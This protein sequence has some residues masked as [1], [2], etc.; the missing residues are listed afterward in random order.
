MDQGTKT[1]QL[2]QVRGCCPPA[3]PGGRWRSRKHL[4]ATKGCVKYRISLPPPAVYGATGACKYRCTLT[5]VS[6]SSEFLRLW[7]PFRPPSGIFG[8]RNSDRLRI[9]PEILPQKAP[10]NSQKYDKVRIFR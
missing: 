4:V 2:Q 7:R 3:V 9:Y 8:G 6:R 5:P 10:G 1:G